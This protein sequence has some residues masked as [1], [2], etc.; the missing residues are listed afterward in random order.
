MAIED[1]P[2]ETKEYIHVIVESDIDLGAL[3]VRM[4]VLPYDARP[5]AGDWQTA[6]WG[7]DADGNT[8]A[9]IKIGPG[10]SLDFSASPGTKIPWVQVTTS[11]EAP[12]MEGDPFEVT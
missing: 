9:K 1:Y 4:T 6:E 10:T 5:Q 7:T 12:V 11:E 3:P 8:I 2:R